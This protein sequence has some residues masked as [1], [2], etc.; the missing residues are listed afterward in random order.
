MTQTA[1]L[2][3]RCDHSLTLTINDINFSCQYHKSK[4]GQFILAFY[5]GDPFAGIGGHRSKGKGFYFLLKDNVLIVM[6]QVE[7]PNDCKVADNGNFIVNDWLF[8]VAT[9]SIGYAFNDKGEVILKKGSKQI[10]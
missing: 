10:C 3:I 2:N 1:T 5:D 9:K 7:R 6:G 8:D 4:S